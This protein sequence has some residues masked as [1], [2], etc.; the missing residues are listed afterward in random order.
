MPTPPLPASPC[1]R[2]RMIQTAEAG[3]KYGNRWYLSYGGS[4]PTAANCATIASDIEAAWAA[5]LASITPSGFELIEIDVLDIATADGL[6]G[7]WTG[8]AAGTRSGTYSPIQ[9]STNV[10]FDIARRY[11]GGKP[12][13][14]LPPGCD[15]DWESPGEWSSEFIGE[16]TTAV[17]AFFAA[18]EAISVGAVGALNH[19]NLSYYSGFTNVEIPGRR[20][21]AIPTYRATALVDN[22]EG[23]AP[24]QVMG[25]QRRRRQSTTP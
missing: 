20:A 18:V 8:T 21:R 19:V 11:R 1:L 24:K 5:H 16:V 14:Y 7:Q 12:R 4:A 2:V 23:Y 6:S 3:E 13:I 9:V 15:T 10:E 22:I 17:P 25:S